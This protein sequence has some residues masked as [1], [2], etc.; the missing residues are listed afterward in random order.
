MLLYVKILIVWS[1]YYMIIILNKFTQNQFCKTDIH[2]FDLFIYSVIILKTTVI[3]LT[4]FKISDKSDKT[5]ILNSGL[6]C[7]LLHKLKYIT[8]KS[9]HQHIII[10][11]KLLCL[12]C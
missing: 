7:K 9:S 2:W 6:K 8:E 4:Y 5:I 3:N 11:T 12:Q 1:P 10:I